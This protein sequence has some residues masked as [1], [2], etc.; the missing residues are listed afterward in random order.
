MTSS[1]FSLFFVQ[2][3]AFKIFNKESKQD[4]YSTKKLIRKCFSFTSAVLE[5]KIVNSLPYYG[6]VTF[7]IDFL[8][9]YNISFIKKHFKLPSDHYFCIF[10]GT[11]IIDI[12]APLG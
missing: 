3:R 11:R 4:L 8:N 12:M 6:H 10:C 5:D 2:R 9:F 7:W 1:K